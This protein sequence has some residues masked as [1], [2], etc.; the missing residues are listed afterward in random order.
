MQQLQSFDPNTTN[1][2]AT[3]QGPALMGTGAAYNSSWHNNK[4]KGK[5]K[6]GHQVEKGKYKGKGYNS[7]YNNKG[8]GKGGYPI[9]QGNPFQQGN[10]FKGASKGKGK[11]PQ[12]ST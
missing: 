12:T 1:Y 6:K 9:G 2:Q 10:P 7:S 11:N 3:S 8:K 5:G 4:G